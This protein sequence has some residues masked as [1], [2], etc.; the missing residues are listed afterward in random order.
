MRRFLKFSL[1]SIATLV[2]VA[3]PEMQ[4][5]QA[6]HPFR[7]HAFARSHCGIGWGGRV[8]YAGWCG[9][10]YG[11]AC[12]PVYSASFYGTGIWGSG[13]N[14][15]YYMINGGCWPS[16]SFYNCPT[17]FYQPAIYSPVIYVPDCYSVNVSAGGYPFA[18]STSLTRNIA[19]SRIANTSQPSRRIPTQLSRSAINTSA[20]R[21]VTN[22]TLPNPRLSVRDIDSIRPVTPYSPIWTEAAVGLIDDMMARGEWEIAYHSCQRME[23]IQSPKNHRVVLRQAVL[24]LVANRNTMSDPSLEHALEL[25]NEAAGV[26]SELAPTELPGGSLAS[27]LKA[28]AIELDPLLDALSRR[29]LEEPES[30]GREMLVLSVLLNLDGQP[31]RA[32]LFT[33]ETR[34][35]AAL[36]STFRWQSV[37]QALDSNALDTSLLAARTTR[38]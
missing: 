38:P 16:Y 15:G 8:G 37:M 3:A 12:A 20:Q 24:D 35:L 7:C 36:S 5:A 25:F 28:S 33:R 9:P 31:E 32:A 2:A 26:G 23:K 6:G 1:A 17:Y 14:R 11:Y 13:F 22:D 19:S 29:V 34:S 27:Y 30:S 21:F 18:S 4:T 10:S